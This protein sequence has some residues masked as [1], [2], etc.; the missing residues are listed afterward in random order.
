[1]E[2]TRKPVHPGKVFF[3]D[4]LV[5]LGVSITD[6]AHR[7][8]ITRKTLS[9]FVNERS[10]CTPQMAIRLAGLTNTSAES[11]LNMQVKY[12][13]WK[14]R[15]KPVAKYDRKVLLIPS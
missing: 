15:Q 8:G 10:S 1:M 6:A 3:L 12:D 4:V 7:I 14:A 5:P 9:E 11:W 2:Q 13:L